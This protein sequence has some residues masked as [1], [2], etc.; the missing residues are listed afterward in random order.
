MKMNPVCVLKATSAASS[1]KQSG[2]S[3]NVMEVEILQKVIV[4]ENLLGNLK[5]YWQQTDI[6]GCL[7]SELVKAVRY[8]L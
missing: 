1:S 5:N 2:G 7:S 4:R 6:S 3:E 8:K